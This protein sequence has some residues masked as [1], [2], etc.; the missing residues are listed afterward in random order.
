[1]TGIQEIAEERTEQIEKHFHS[2]AN[3]VVDNDQGQLSFV[4]G[5]I[6]NQEA[7]KVPMI[8]NYCPPGWDVSF[9]MKLVNKPYKQRLRI[10]GALIAAEI[11]RI[12]FKS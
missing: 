9:F 7:P 3:D 10:A 11:D 1:M 6:S 12:N 8:E 4:A 5:L 2:I